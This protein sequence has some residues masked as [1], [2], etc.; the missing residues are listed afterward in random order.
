MID[1][2]EATRRA[3]LHQHGSFALAYS[4]AFQPG[5]SY[6]GDR[7][8]FL[9]YRM[10]GRTA[11]V[12]SNPLADAT[13]CQTLLEQ[14]I[15]AK[16]DVCFAQI[17]RPTAEMLSGLG[18]YINEMGTETSLDLKTFDFRGPSRRNF[19]TAVKRFEAGG[20]TARESL[21]A[22]LHPDGARAISEQWRRTRTTK[23]HEL[24]FLVRPVV[25]A[26]EP[27]VRKFFIF[28]PSGKP[29]A[30]AFF[31]PVYENGMLTGYLSSTRRRLPEIEPLAGYYLLH[32]AIE[33]FRAE[34]VRTLHLGVSPFHEIHDKDFNKNWLVRRSFRFVYTN[35]LTNRFIYP[36]QSLAKHKDSYG[37]T[38]QQTYFAVNTMPSLP[39]LLKLLWVCR[40]I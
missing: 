24:S 26:D 2:P 36:F 33:K 22:A 18:F 15:A 34:G 30:F 23:R 20:Y 31:D 27:D 29:V 17:S 4:A 3:L 37:G 25:L 39:R 28:D 8:G 35:A 6:F 32:S 38:K 21:V 40:I 7:D 9:A 1:L 14:F 11:F 13:R 12:L 19:R 16:K 5:L 10:V